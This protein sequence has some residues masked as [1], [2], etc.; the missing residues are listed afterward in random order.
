MDFTSFANSLG[1]NDPVRP[2]CKLCNSKF[3]KEAERLVETGASILS[4]KRMLEREGEDISYGAV[5]NHINYH[6]KTKQTE[7]D[8]KEYATQL[9]KWGQM[10]MSEEELIRRYIKM[11]DIEITYLCSKNAHVDMAE[12][13]KNEDMIVKM[14]NQVMMLKEAAKKLNA[15]MQ[16]IEIFTAAFNRIIE[17]KLKTS[18]SPEAKKA[19]QDVIDQLKK[20]V[21]EVPIEG[22]KQ[23][24]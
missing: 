5:A 8:L 21:G 14:Q 24:I 23:E 4:I 17:I 12:R 13:R 7:T 1:D 11:L 22:K 9:E 20:E 18:I 10:S 3:R 2:N 19:L 15:E 6:F 16:P